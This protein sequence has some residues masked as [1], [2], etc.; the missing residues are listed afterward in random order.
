MQL[1]VDKIYCLHHPPL[2]ARH[3]RL[4]EFFTRT[5]LNPEWVTGYLPEEITI[6]Q[7][8]KIMNQMI[9]KKIIELPN[10]SVAANIEFAKKKSKNLISLYKKQMYCVEQ[11]VEKRFDTILILEDDV[12][13]TDP[14]FNEEYVNE[15]L[16]EFKKLN[17]DLLF[18]GTCCDLHSHNTPVY[19]H[20]A[21]ETTSRCA[22]MYV[23]T[24]RAAEKLMLHLPDMSDAYDWK[25]NEIIKK[26]N[27]NVYWVEPGIEQF[28]YVS[29]LVGEIEGKTEN[30]EN[31]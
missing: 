25:L 6:E 1:D 28:G 16:T 19:K 8:H 27:L 11:Q 21:K 20:I 22:H 23:I 18:I 15:C 5:N 17:G 12:D 10:T 4:I 7:C 30:K 2:V 24:L 3:K 13:T 29:S 9:Q 14:K 31:K 26:E